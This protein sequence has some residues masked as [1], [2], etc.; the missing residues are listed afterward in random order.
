MREGREYDVRWIGRVGRGRAVW[1][2]E[3]GEGRGA[4]LGCLGIGMAGLRRLAF[5]GVV[6]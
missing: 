5:V 6:K 4:V 2:F 1:F 3:K